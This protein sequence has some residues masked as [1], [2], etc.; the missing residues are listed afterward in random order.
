MK[1][2]IISVALLLVCG[3]LSAQNINQSVQVTNE[4]QAKFADFPKQELSISVPDTLYS[5]DYN[6]DYAVFET[7]YKGSYEFSPYEIALNL[8]PVRYD[9]KKFYL[10]AGAGVGL[11]PK[12]DFVYN[13]VSSEKFNLSVYNRGSG[14]VLGYGHNLRDDLALTGRY[15]MPSAELDFTLGYDGIFAR[16][17]NYAPFV[18]YSQAQN[19]LASAYNSAFAR[20]SIASSEA[21]TS[22]IAYRLGVDYRY[23]AE[24]VGASLGSLSESMMGVSGYLAFVTNSRH[25]MLL[26]Y[27]F[28]MENVNNKIAGAES[29]AANLGS[30]TPQL[31]FAL[32]AFDIKLGVKLDYASA[33]DKGSLGLYPAVRAQVPLGQSHRAFVSVGGGREVNQHFALKSMY[34]F[35]VRRGSVEAFAKEKYNITLGLDGVLGASLQYSL[36]GGYASWE[37]LPLASLKN[38]G[39]ADLSLFDVDLDAKYI[40]ENFDLDADLHL[41]LLSKYAAAPAYAPALFEG[42]LTARYNWYKRIYASAGIEARTARKDLGGMLADVPGYIDLKLGAEYSFSSKIGAYA[43]IGNLLFQHIERCPGFAEKGPYVTVG[44]IVNL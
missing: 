24:T 34:P 18:I 25:K 2:S 9:I 14:E 13:A 26:D 11:H 30:V 22:R 15:V 36:K 27:N 39:F 8:D 19:F 16:D 3:V 12:L 42:Q 1:K 44:I 35:F 40:S 5:F 43:E 17:N 32:G 28:Q 41:N 4:Y 23:G 6:F 33:G 38:I 20:V 31:L 7:K 29:L 10:K 21:S 37:D